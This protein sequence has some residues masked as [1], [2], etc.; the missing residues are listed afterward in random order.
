MKTSVLSL[1][2][3]TVLLL[4]FFPMPAFAQ[5]NAKPLKV[6]ILAGQSNMQGHADVSTIDYIGEDPKTAPMLLEMRDNNGKYRL[7]KDTWISYLT[8]GRGTPNGEGIGQLTVGFGARKDP[9][10]DDGK[11]GPE[12]TFGIYMQ[13]SLKQPI[14]I[15]KTAWG[16]KNLNTDFRPPG[17][18]PYEFNDTQLEGFKKQGKD[19]EKIKAEKAKVTGH[20]YRLMID[21]VKK[22]LADIK[23]VYPDYDPKAG[24]ELAG[25]VWFQGWNDMV[26]RS[27]YLNR[28]KPAGYHIYSELLAQFIRDVRKDLSTT[29][30]PFVIGVMGVGG[31]V[32]KYSSDQLRY[33]EIHH[34]FRMAMAAPAALPEFKGNVVAVLTEKY[35]DM[36][37]VKLREREKKIKQ[38]VDEVNSKMKEGKLSREKGK[39]ALDKL[40]AETFTPRE[41]E[42]LKKSTSNFDFH[43]M[44]SAKIMA[45]IG[46]GF[47]EAL[48]DMMEGH[49]HE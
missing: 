29:K 21:H 25:F 37:V 10:K 2:M 43:Y 39:A 8:H 11:I 19:K 26:D 23:Q 34:N 22:V 41:M 24:Y 13:K 35:W 14:L 33:K 38:K 15:I 32:E 7:V 17:A 16:G 6:F 48:V 31:P 42:I 20:Y 49:N 30:L 47:A 46:K 36:E 28:G 18:G 9:T 3:S 5:S 45:Q 27:T 44:G 1:L 40:Y 12:F 4:V